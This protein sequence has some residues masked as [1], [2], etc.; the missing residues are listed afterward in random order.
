MEGPEGGGGGWGILISF[1]SKLFFSN[2][3]S[4]CSSPTIPACVAQTEIPFPFFYCFCFMNLSPSAQNPI[5]Q[6]LKRHIP[7]PILP[8]QDP[9]DAQGFDEDLPC[10]LL[11]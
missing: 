3:S 4:T 1:P 8:L 11:T 2:P 9:H 5:P 6:A 7:A 10:I